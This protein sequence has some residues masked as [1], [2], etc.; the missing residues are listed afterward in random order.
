MAAAHP[1]DFAAEF[2]IAPD[3]III[4]NAKT[5]NDREWFSDGSI[6][7]VG[8]EPELRLM[9]HCQDNCVHAFHRGPD[10]LLDPQVFQ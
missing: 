5:I 10:I 4:E 8:I 7:L 6:N 9:P 2:E 1:F 3:F